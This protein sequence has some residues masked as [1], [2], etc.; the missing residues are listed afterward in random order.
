MKFNKI[1]MSILASGMIMGLTA[2]PKPVVCDP[3]ERVAVTSP[4]K[5]FV[6][7]NTFNLDDYVTISG[8]CGPKS[9]EVT[10][11]SGSESIVSVKDHQVTVLDEGEFK[12]KISAGKGDA[13]K[14]ANF[15][16]I[17]YGE[18]KARFD[19]VIKDLAYDYAFDYVDVEEDNKKLG[20]IVHNANYF[21]QYYETGT[22][23]DF[24]E[25]MIRFKSGRAYNFSATDKDGNGL[26]IGERNDNYDLYFVNM[27]WF[28]SASQVV[29]KVDGAGQEYLEIPSTV[30]A[31]DAEYFDSLADEFAASALGVGSDDYAISSVN[32]YCEE[33][34]YLFEVMGKAIDTTASQEEV[35]LEDCVLRVGE[36]AKK[37]FIEKAI[38]DDIE[39]A[40]IDTTPLGAAIDSIV[41]ADNYT[42]TFFQYW[43]NSKGQMVDLSTSENEYAQI[44]YSWTEYAQETIKVDNVNKAVMSTVQA[45]QG[46][47]FAGRVGGFVE[48]EGKV[49][50]LDNQEE[51][52]EG[53][54][55]IT[56]TISA[57]E[58]SIT[59]DQLKATYMLNGIGSATN[60]FKNLDVAAVGSQSGLS[61]YQFGGK[62]SN[63]QFV[64]TLFNISP[65][66]GFYAN[67]LWTN[68][69][70]EVDGAYDYFSVVAA[71]GETTPLLIQGGES[72]NFGGGA[73]YK[74]NFQ[75]SV[76]AV[77]STTV[78][79]S[80]I[81]FPGFAPIG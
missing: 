23:G 27:K 65:V 28:L 69:F 18:L 8:G 15:N 70:K 14:T 16:G 57:T 21:W 26:E 49:Y 75:I 74:Y 38:A 11:A 35:V 24:Y 2:C 42:V 50:S 40:G 59:S 51:D 25:G 58:E 62:G 43:T 5:A 34:V 79:T 47:S 66:L 19:N 52:A 78:D 55:V 37:A 10:V 22:A 61:V 73:V 7:G 80:G 77:G 81:V 36:A 76:S 41:T 44:Y 4:K 53:K 1:V 54:P 13:V 60:A 67:Y 17:A 30:A 20:E 48:K 45:A 71:F 29:S 33:G 63:A 31:P 46:S 12:L 72:V 32:V 9:Y 68:G 56:N 3:V 39:P 6:V 64:Y